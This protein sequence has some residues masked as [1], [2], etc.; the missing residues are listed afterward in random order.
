MFTQY[1]ATSDVYG[2]WTIDRDKPIRTSFLSTAGCLGA[3]YTPEGRYRYFAA[4]KT[5]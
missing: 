2:Q 5:F 1:I 3:I 4:H